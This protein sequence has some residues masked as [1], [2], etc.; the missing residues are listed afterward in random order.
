MEK[1]AFGYIRRSSH[2]QL[3]NN[4]IDIQKQRIQEYAKRNKMNIPDEFIFTDDAT[5]GYSIPANKRTELMRLAEKMIELNI[6]RVVFNDT[7]RM[8]RTGSTFILYF[9]RRLIEQLP[10]L[11][12]Y[13]TDSDQPID[14]K[15]PKTKLD[16]L[17]AQNESENK[18]VRAIG[19]LINVLIQEPNFRPGSKT[20]FGYDQI[21]KKLYP[22]EDAEIVLFIFY[23]YSWGHSLNKIASILNEADIPSPSG[24][25]WRSSSIENILKNPVYTGNLHWKISKYKEGENQF[26]F[27]N[28]HTPIVNNF[29]IQL[30]NL[31]KQLQRNYGR[32]DTSFL[33]LNKLHCEHCSEVLKTQNGSTKRNNKKYDYFYYVCSNCNYKIEA[34]ELELIL[35]SDIMEKV[36][37]LV[38][39][40]CFKSSTLEYI[41]QMTK[42]TEKKLQEKDVVINTL[43][44]KL[45]EAKNYDD[46]QLQ[47]LILS[48]IERHKNEANTLKHCLTELEILS[49]A[50]SDNLFFSRFHHILTNE[51]DCVEKRLII[52][53][54]ID[55]IKIS[56]ENLKFKIRY[57]TNIFEDFNQQ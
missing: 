44:Q 41:D 24:S 4:S 38:V 50:V 49:D 36:H 21:D 37:N 18:S 5:S 14:P 54:F 20:P 16:F 55:F 34:R 6:D 28:T 33:F 9:Y 30:H 45:L 47:Q 15:S 1:L 57:K 51:L 56:K 27:K 11:K 53:Y 23:L 39:N 22:N 7:S 10:N 26:F 32:L 17:I 13:T 48:S 43:S 19:S 3:D 29:L 2:K 46:C 8:D 31:N 42:E 25:K 52:L 35:L 12:V 40:R